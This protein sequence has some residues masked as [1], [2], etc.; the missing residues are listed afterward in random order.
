MNRQRHT[1]NLWSRRSALAATGGLALTACAP[2]APAGPAVDP[3][4]VLGEV[5]RI[6][7]DL[8]SVVAA[9][10]TVEKLGEGFQWAEGPLWIREANYLLFTD[11][12]GNCMYKWAEGAGVSEFLKPSGFAG[13]DAS[14][15]REPGANGLAREAS[16][17]VLVAD[18][19]NRCLSRLDLATKQKTTLVDTFEGKKFNSPNDVVVHST[20]AVYFTDP[21]YGLEGMADSPLREIAFHGVYRLAP[22][23]TLRVVDDKLAFPN[24]VA[25][26]PDERTLYVSCS[27]D[28]RQIVMAYSLGPDGMPTSSAVFFDASPMISPDRPGKPDGI[29]V[30]QDGRLYQTGPGGVLVISPQ[31][32]L[33]GVIG[34]G[35]AVANCKFGADG[36]TLFLTA[37]DALGRIRLNTKAAGWA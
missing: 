16:G 19:G 2:A 33:L 15:L 14:H 28:V 8:D 27:D 37:H 4:T 7:P 12:P 29:A 36:S 21:P 30:D 17:A 34:A 10:A 6:S 9:G 20:G 32:E 35:R 31:A 23:G 13:A 22:D 1:S 3:A 26:S 24:G 25:L 11:V 5:A 18:C